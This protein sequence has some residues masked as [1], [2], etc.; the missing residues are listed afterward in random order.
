MMQTTG[1]QRNFMDKIRKWW[2][3]RR[4]GVSSDEDE[5][6]RSGRR[7]KK[8]PTGPWPFWRIV[9]WL[10]VLALVCGICLAAYFTLKSDFGECS[11]YD[12]RCD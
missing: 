12:V 8:K 4:G 10:G 11:E 2:R 6:G 3:R 7:E 9:F 5:I 1:S